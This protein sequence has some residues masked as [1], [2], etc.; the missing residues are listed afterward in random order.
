MAELIRNPR[1]MCKAQGKVWRVLAGRAGDH[2]GGQPERSALPSARHQ[3]AAPT[4][5][6]GAAANPTGVLDAVPGPAIRRADGGYDSCQHVGHRQEL[7]D[8]GI[9]AGAV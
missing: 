2:H 1:V 8:G 7:G 6:S 4:A 5:A 9:L 3:G